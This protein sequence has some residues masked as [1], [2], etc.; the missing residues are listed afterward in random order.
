[1]RKLILIIGVLAMAATPVLADGP[2]GSHE[3]DTVD[4]TTVYD[5]N[6]SCG[7]GEATPA[8]TIYAGDN[9]VEVC[10]DGSGALPLQGRIIATSDDGGYIAADGDRDNSPEQAQGWVR[11]DSGGVRCGDSAGNNDATHPT[12]ADT[13]E[14]CG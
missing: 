13:S 3:E 10:N 7:G 9:G 6:V 14:D 12:A 4:G 11:L 2:S 1:M 5:N 8:G